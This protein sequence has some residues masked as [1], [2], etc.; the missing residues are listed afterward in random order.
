MLEAQRQA[1]LPQTDRV[2]FEQ[3]ADASHFIRHDADLRYPLLD[4]R[5][6]AVIQDIELRL[7]DIPHE[8]DGE[9]PATAIQCVNAYHAPFLTSSARASRQSRAYQP[10][11]GSLIVFLASVCPPTSTL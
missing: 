5:F 4:I 7:I 9:G 8:F 6:H 2:S 11:H 10:P 1:Q 3:W